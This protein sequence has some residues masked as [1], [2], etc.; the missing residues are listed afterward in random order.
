MTHQTNMRG[1]EALARIPQ[2]LLSA[3]FGNAFTPALGNGLR[4]THGLETHCRPH[5]NRSVLLP[6]NPPCLT[7]TRGD[8]AQSPNSRRKVNRIHLGM[9]LTAVPASD[10]QSPFQIACGILI[11]RWQWADGLR[12]SRIRSLSNFWFTNQGSATMIEIGEG[13]R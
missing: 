9:A 12:V 4:I 10:R 2:F 1:R 11:P 6:P 7:V 3:I 5:S 13:R 8:K